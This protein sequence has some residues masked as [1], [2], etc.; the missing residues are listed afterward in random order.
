MKY[1]KDNYRIP[2]NPEVHGKWKA[3]RNCSSNIAEYNWIELWGS[4]GSGDS[5]VNFE[6]KFL[7]KSWALL[8]VA[9]SRILEFALCRTTENYAKCHR[10]KRERVEAFISSQGTTSSGNASSSAMRRSNSARCIS[11]RGKALASRQMLAQ[12]SST[13][14]SLSSTPSR[15]MPKVLMVTPMITSAE[16][17][18]LARAR[19]CCLKGYNVMLTGAL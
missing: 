4:C 2:A 7:A 15:S 12:I 3:A 6:G 11:V 19:D 18:K 8:V 5:L 1:G 17:V 14:A 16:S 13:S 10:P 9:V